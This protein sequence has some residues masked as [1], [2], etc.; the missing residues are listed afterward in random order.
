MERHRLSLISISPGGTTG[1]RANL[2]ASVASNREMCH[3]ELQDRGEHERCG[4]RISGNPIIPRRIS[5]RPTISPS[6][7]R[8]SSKNFSNSVRRK[9]RNTMFCTWVTGVRTRRGPHAPGRRKKPFPAIA[10]SRAHRHGVC[11]VPKDGP[12]ASSRP[13]AGYSAAGRCS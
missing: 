5:L 6:K 4:R 1:E 11:N 8:R 9:R 2:P 12:K 13:A 7:T 3:R 10:R